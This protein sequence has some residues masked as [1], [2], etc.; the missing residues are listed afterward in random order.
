TEALELVGSR[1]F[2][3]VLLDLMMPVMSGFDFLE[4]VRKDPVRRDV[5]ILVMSAASR[6][7]VERTARDAGVDFITKPVLIDT[8][9]EKVAERC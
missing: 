5:S 6:D 4:A 8:L 9:L 2:D 1:P 7:V 3:L